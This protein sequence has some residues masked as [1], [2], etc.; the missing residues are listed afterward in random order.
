MKLFPENKEL[1]KYTKLSEL[2]DCVIHVGCCYAKTASVR[3]F[4]DRGGD[5]YL[6][7]FLGRL[8]CS[9][10]GGRPKSA[11]LDSV[12]YYRPGLEGAQRLWLIGSEAIAP[13]W[14]INRRGG[15]AFMPKAT[16]IPTNSVCSFAS[17]S[18]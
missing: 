10:C 11:L 2:D 9:K 4:M 17:A 14:M 12:P 15:D 5:Q 1:A 7:E 8:T 3:W 18:A 13:I 6:G 16:N